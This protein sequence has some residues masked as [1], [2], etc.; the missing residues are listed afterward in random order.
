[1]LSI[2]GFGRNSDESQRRAYAP[3]IHAESGLLARQSMFDDRPAADLGLALADT[4][5]ALHGTVAVLAALRLRDL[6]GRGQHI[7]L[8]M[9][10]A[11]IAS[12]DYTHCAID[13]I[14]EPYPSRGD[15]W[16][17][18]GG[19]IMIA[20][21]AKTLW[22][23]FV[24]YTGAADPA[25]PGDDGPAKVSARR[26]AIAAWVAGFAVR[27][28][29]L[30]ALDAAN[31]AWADLRDPVSVLESPAL[32]GEA[33]VAA[34]EDHAGGTRGVVRMPYNFS[35][36]ESRVRG[37]APR[38]GQHND[39]VLRDWLDLDEQDVARLRAGGALLD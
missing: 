34:V 8:G 19:P 1:M 20:A 11:M 18:A 15:I 6:T 22:T 4:I 13:G 16:S 25:Q 10:Q 32:A 35:S 37:G 27:A 30:A 39:D 38:R 7:D 29:L 5:A 2:S 36:A 17:A 3:V 21:D 9:L 24:A 28:D 26:A 33:L 14:A 23:R 31:L 12:D